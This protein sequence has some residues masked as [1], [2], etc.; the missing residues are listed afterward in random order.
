M[1]SLSNLSLAHNLITVVEC[2]H[3]RKGLT[4]QSV[5]TAVR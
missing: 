1:N 4:F 2:E 5:K 3:Q